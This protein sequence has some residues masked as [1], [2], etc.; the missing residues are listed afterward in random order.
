MKRDPSLSLFNMG[1]IIFNDKAFSFLLCIF[2]IYT[3]NVIPFPVFLHSQKPS[4]YHP[5]LCFYEVVP[6]TTCTLLPPPPS[7]SCT[8]VH[9]VFR[10]PRASSLIDVQPG[11]PLLPMQLQ[12]WLPLCVLFGWWFSP[13][14]LWEYWLVH[15]IVPPMRLQTPSAP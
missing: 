6:L 10:G 14:E 12:P 4:S 13:W 3:S 5:S 9:Q 15:I 8:K 1:C 2:F 7:H 11:H